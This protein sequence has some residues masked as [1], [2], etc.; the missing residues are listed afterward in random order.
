MQASCTFIVPGSPAGKAR[1][2]FN[3]KSGHAYQPDPG[4]FVANVKLFGAKA[5]EA[6][7]LDPFDGPVRME[8]VATRAIPKSASKRKRAKDRRSY[9]RLKA[10]HEVAR[11]GASEAKEVDG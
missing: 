9:Y 10:A 3:R 5:A 1:P 11:S 6:A 4:N 8:L 7:G 2:R